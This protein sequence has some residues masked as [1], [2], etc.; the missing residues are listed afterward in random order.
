MDREGL[1]QVFGAALEAIE[2]SSLVDAAARRMGLESFGKPVTVL[3]LGKAAAGMTSGLASVFDDI[4]GVAVTPEAATLPAD[5]VGYVGAHPIPNGS[6]VTAGRA[7]LA[8]ASAAPSDALVVCLLSGG[9]SALAELPVS[10][11]SIEQVALLT[12]RLL[13]AGAS[14]EEL[15]AVRVA[16]SQLKGGGLAA[17]VKSPH[18]VTLAI[19]DVG[20][21]PDAVIASGPTLQIDGPDPSGVFKKYGIAELLTGAVASAVQRSRRRDHLA[22]DF[23]VIASGETAARA[24]ADAV[25]ASGSRPLIAE[26][27]LSGEARDEARRIVAGR[28]GA[29]VVEVH[30][31]E[32]TVTVSGTG[33]GGRNH[34]AALAAAI[35]LDGAPGIFLAAGT[36]GVDGSGGGAGAVVDGATAAE[37][38]SAGVDAYELLAD[39]DSGAF[40]DVVPGRLDVG[41]TGT[42][43]ADLWMFANG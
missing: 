17:A 11:V 8:A 35:A 41:P 43:V 15:N 23:E 34:E 18:L 27:V 22:G 32:T 21:L 10:G 5:V 7:L 9:G 24:A 20:R 14:I 2:P 16:F 38:R 30:W 3:A 12:D 39:N 26:R 6:S 28:P 29:G 36:D 25:A 42:N 37:G 19:S 1:S 13:R 4:V 40:F 33:R 31:G